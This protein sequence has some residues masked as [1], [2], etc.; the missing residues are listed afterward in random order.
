MWMI[1]IL[2]K[3]C[4]ICW[5]GVA[6]QSGAGQSLPPSLLP[7][8]ATFAALVA[9]PF[10]AR[11]GCCR[12]RWQWA[13]DVR[14]AFVSL[15]APELST[16]CLALGERQRWGR[17]LICVLH[18]VAFYACASRGQTLSFQVGATLP[19]LVSHHRLV[20]WVLPEPGAVQTWPGKG[21]VVFRLCKPHLVAKNLLVWESCWVWMRADLPQRWAELL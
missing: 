12:A 17:A 20:L 19:H 5:V 10:W 18:F 11:E 7:G 8:P 1:F 2:Y 16:R 4:G 13:V 21:H 9:N 15:S 14:G 6:Q 3:A